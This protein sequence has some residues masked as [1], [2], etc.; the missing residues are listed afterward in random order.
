MVW[1]HI[2][3]L[4]LP[5]FHFTHRF[6]YLFG[7]FFSNKIYRV[8]FLFYHYLSLVSYVD[9]TCCVQQLGSMVIFDFLTYVLFIY[10]MIKFIIINYCS[11]YLRPLDDGFFYSLLIISTTFF[12]TLS[13]TFI[14]ING[15]V[16]VM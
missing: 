12:K 8:S 2:N 4:K 6:I 1:S 9:F 10:Q 11:Q 16:V 5:Q 3:G 13:D 15:I 7:F 14:Y